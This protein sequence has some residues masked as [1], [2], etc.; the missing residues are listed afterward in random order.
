MWYQKGRDVWKKHETTLFLTNSTNFH[1]KLKQL[2]DPACDQQ[3]LQI[4]MINS[5]AKHLKHK[6]D[7][8]KTIETNIFR[9]FTVQWDVLHIKTDF[10][11][12]ELF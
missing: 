4:S 6:N 8:D 3:V 1:N 11:R 2:S 10:V 7:F 12:I 5:L 9:C